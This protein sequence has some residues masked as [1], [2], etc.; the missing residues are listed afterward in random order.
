MEGGGRWI[1]YYG[2]FLLRT[3]VK[4]TLDCYD[5][6]E[7]GPDEITSLLYEDQR[8]TLVI[9]HL[10]KFY[11]GDGREYDVVV[12]DAFTTTDPGVKIV[13]YASEFFSRKDQSVKVEPFLHD[14]EGRVFSHPVCGRPVKSECP[15]RVCSISAQ[16]SQTYGDYVFSSWFGNFDGGFYLYSHGALL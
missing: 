3:H 5:L 10:P 9:R 16:L 6:G 15:C 1:Q 11:N 7:S 2:Y 12:D 4:V 14:T 13:S 8:H